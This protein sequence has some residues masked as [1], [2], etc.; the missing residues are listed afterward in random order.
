[1]QN[2]TERRKGNSTVNKKIAIIIERA[3]TMLGGAERSV[4]EL[5]GALSKLGVE[6]D[7]LAAKGQTSA[8][9]IH[10]LCQQTAGKR[11]CY[12]TFRKALKKY[13]AENPY[14]LVHSVV[15]F[16][17]ADLYQPRGGSYA[18]SILR[19]AASY[20][21]RAVGF[22]KKLTAFANFRRTILLQA[23]GRLCKNP[24]GPVIA[25]LSR[26][27][28][29]QFKHHYG[30]DESRITIVPNGVKIHKRIDTAEAGRLREQ[31]LAKLSL[32]EA[33]RPV[34]FLFV[35]NNFRLKGLAS[36]ICALHSAAKHNTYLIIAGRDK[37]F[38]YRRLG[39]KLDVHKKIIFL[40]HLR[41]IQNMLSIIDVAVLPTF[42]DP[43]SR[44]ILEA[45]S[46]GRPVIT[47]RYNGAADFVTNGRHGKIVDS[48]ENIT[49]LA[50]AIGYFSDTENIRKAS[51]AIIEDNLAEKISIARAAEQMLAVYEEILKKRGL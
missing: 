23:E 28:A 27:V 49:A 35:A 39:K 42:Y 12:F 10:I 29:E 26:Y 31:I 4:F 7:I 2:T 43:A 47:T 14:S 38:K 5:A 22:F 15:P 45:L 41:S 46:A 32:T 34:L 44:F 9:N 8:K 11:V 24:D 48:P 19:N 50:E 16:G 17:F 40:G 51:Q 33:D 37:S 30:V 25:A 6:V 36:L 3:D 1:L 21:N 13:L 18:E 20:Q